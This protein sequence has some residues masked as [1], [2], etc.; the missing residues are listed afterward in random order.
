MKNTIKFFETGSKWLR[1]DFHLHTVSDPLGIKFEDNPNDFFNRFLDKLEE[2]KINVGVITN[3]N[4]FYHD[5]FKELRK[6]AWKRDVFLLPG[7]ELNVGDG[8]NG[9]HTLVV[10]D[11]EAWVDDKKNINNI[12]KFL[13]GTFGTKP[14]KPDGNTEEK[15]MQTIKRLNEF[16]AGYFIILAHVDRDKGFFKETAR[17]IRER[18]IYSEPLF[19]DHVIGFQ[20]LESDK[21][22]EEIIE[23]YGS[24]KLPAFLDGSDPKT[25]DD[26]GQRDSVTYI[27][28]GDFN[29][30]AVKYALLA[31]STRIK[32]SFPK[33]KNGY[34]KDISFVGGMLD[35][36]TVHLNPD[37]NNLIGIRGSGKSTLLEAIRCA[38]DY[39][40]D[41]QSKDKEYKDDLVNNLL[42][43]GGKIV[44]NIVDRHGEKYR[45][46]K[47]HKEKPQIFRGENRVP[48]MKIAGGLVDVLYFGQ[49]DL[50]EIGGKGFA[51]DLIEKFF[52]DKNEVKEVR[53]QV[54]DKE[55]DIIRTLN[56]INIL[57]EKIKKRD[58]LLEEKSNIEEKLRKFKEHKVDEKLQ[59]QVDFNRDRD[60]LEEIIDFLQTIVDD[61]TG[62]IDEH[63]GSFDHYL[64][65]KSPGNESLFEKIKKSLRAFH[66]KFIEIDSLAHQGKEYLTKLKEIKE[67]FHRLNAELQEEFAQIRRK[68][69]LPT[70]NADDFI[71][72][73]NR[74]TIVKAT[75]SQLEKKSQELSRLKRWLQDSLQ[76]LKDLRHKEFLL[77][78]EETDRLKEKDLSIKIK[79]EF[80]EDKEA[81]EN[82]FKNNFKGTY[83]SANH[84]KKICE[85]YRDPIDIYDDLFK[86]DS[87]L[88][89]ILTGTEG[90]LLLRFKERIEDIRDHFLTFRVPDKVE[91]YYNQKELSKHSLGQRASAFIVFILAKKDH[92]IIIIDQPE[93]DLDNQSLYNDVIK[94]LTKLKQQTQFIFATHNPNIPVLGECEQVLQCSYSENS[95]H[96]KTGSIDRKSIQDEIVNVMEG[97]EEA[98]D[99]RKRIYELW[100]N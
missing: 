67:E 62:I 81:F 69:D 31:N 52:G 56:S 49:K 5:E 74:L 88:E 19:K 1:A 90:S 33:R 34:I 6:K 25:L 96:L 42:G 35:G 15:L 99:K 18:G 97:G 37:M 78:K 59:R 71:N 89:K 9:I 22:K 11:Y 3:H 54:F 73:N 53:K 65:Y 13:N 36:Q 51:G 76:D 92:E 91:L 32:K 98:F 44:V 93:D 14:I 45:I 48:T 12:E 66:K 7:V 61:L 55:Q 80:K 29:F 83:L 57:K 28:I 64:E 21:S 43:S 100:K 17:G 50:S 30:E 40:F 39:K 63:K 87:S 24:D 20:K 47:I 70:L 68:I 23:I 16:R 58:E 82:F 77:L 75:L 94:E 27:K 8:K 85:S 4:R 10:F 95:I 86:K 60:K 38:L 72:F 2:Q 46:E 41:K 26:I 84:I 79:I